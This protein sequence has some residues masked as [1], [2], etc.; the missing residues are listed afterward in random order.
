EPN[1][2]GVA[3]LHAPDTGVVDYAAVSRAIRGELEAQAVHLRF[4][5]HVETIDEIGGV[6]TDRGR[7]RARQVVVCAGLWADRLARA[8]GAPADPRI[9]PFRGAYLTL[10][11]TEEPWVRGMIY[12]V[13]DPA[14]PFLGVH[15]THHLDGRVSL[16]PTALLVGARD[17]YRVTRLR[18]RDL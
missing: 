15:L 3:A 6:T 4:G 8:A 13:P 9:V 7:I 1:A 11:P 5:E 18:P 14:L 16:G 12:P 10:A 17:A 2:V